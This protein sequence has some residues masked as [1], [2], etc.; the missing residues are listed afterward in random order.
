[1]T[2]LWTLPPRPLHLAFLPDVSSPIKELLWLAP[3]LH[4]A[5]SLRS[6]SAVLFLAL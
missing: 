6:V 4:L 3:A 2:F 1:M 5:S